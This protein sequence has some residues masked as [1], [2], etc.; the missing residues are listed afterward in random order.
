M[1]FRRWLSVTFFT[2]SITMATMAIFSF[3]AFV[4]M[5]FSC[6]YQRFVPGFIFFTTFIPM[7]VA[8]LFFAAFVPM[9]TMATMVTLLF[10][11]SITMIFR[12]WLSMTFFAAFV[13][14]ATMATMAILLF[15]TSITMVFRS[16]LSMTFFAAH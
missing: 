4:P 15:T 13:P 5:F 7:A 12:S 10:T 3:A 9:A 16:W 14:V 6:W 11:T 2:A 1:F 8:I